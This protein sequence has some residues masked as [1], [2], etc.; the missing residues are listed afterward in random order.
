MARTVAIGV[1]DFAVIRERKC[2]YVDKTRFIREWWNSQD[3]VTAIMRPRR[4]GKTLNMSMVQAFFSVDYREKGDALFEGL[5]IW[6]DI[7]M[8]QLQGQ[9]P[10]ILITFADIKCGSYEETMEALKFKIFMLAGDYDFLQNSDK[11]G[12]REKQALARLALDMSDSTAVGALNVLCRALH[13]YYG[14]KVIILL[15]EYDTPMQEAYVKGYWA[16]LLDFMRQF[17]NS[18]FK[19]NPAL[20]R[21]L[22]TGITRIA[23]ESIFSD[24]N[25]PVIAT[26]LSDKYADAFGFTQQEVFQ[27]MEEYGL[28]DREQVKKW[29]DGFTIGSTNDIYNPWSIINFIDNGGRFDAYWTNTSSNALVGSLLQTGSEEIKQQFE[30]LLQEKNIQV[31]LEEEVVFDQLED[32]QEAI[33]SLLYTGGYLTGHAISYEDRLYSLRITNYETWLM[34]RGLVQRWF[35]KA[36]GAYNAFIKYLLSGDIRAMNVYMNQLV[37]TLLSSFDTGRKP[38]A[39]QPERFYHGLVLGLMVDLRDRY[40]VT[41]NGESGFGRY[42]VMLEPRHKNDDAFIFEFK[43]QDSALEESLQATVDSAHRQ[44]EEK[45]YDNILL[46]KGIP[47]HRIKKYGFAFSGKKVL[48]G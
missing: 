41:S 17:F 19:T 43:V 20:E 30:M 15:D 14:R 35:G 13:S 10:V 22:L 23:K 7:D 26:M 16:Q 39:T 25:H 45:H 46:E 34:F 48:I 3:A 36:R 21:A 47:V 8:K 28:E 33:W 18:T 37:Q 4:F 5:D 11:V 6:Q 1:Q 38:S 40:V 9:Y 31:R 42:D 29:Y 12:L 2:L 32:N 24:F 27:V 44:I